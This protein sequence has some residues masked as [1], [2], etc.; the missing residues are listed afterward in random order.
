MFKTYTIKN[1]KNIGPLDSR[2]FVVLFFIIYYLIIFV[3][4]GL[5]VVDMIAARTPF[6]TI[7]GRSL[8]LFAYSVFCMQVILGSRIKVLDR[9][10]GLDR[11]LRFHRR[12]AIIGLFA[13]AV[14]PLALVF[15][16][17]VHEIF[18]SIDNI[19]IICGK[20]AFLILIIGVAFALFRA[21]IKLDYN[22]WH[23]FHK[24]M[25]IIILLGF[26]HSMNLGSSL[27]TGAM[28]NY[29]WVLTAIPIAVFIFKNSIG[30]IQRN[31]FQVVEVKKENHNVW[32]L[33]MTPVNS[34]I[35]KYRPGQFMFLTLKR[36][37]YR[38]EEHPFTIS[39]AP[40]ENEYIS[41]TIKKSGDYT[42]TIGKTKPGDIARISG[43]Y[44]RFSYVYNEPSSFV[45][46]AGGVGITPLMS[47]MRFIRNT[48]DGRPVIL[49][50]ANKAE[51]DIIFLD[52]FVEFPQNFEV[53]HIL[54]Q[55]SKDWLGEVGHVEMGIIEKYCAKVLDSAHFYLCGPKPMMDSV[56]N[57]LTEIGIDHSR[58]HSE[59]FR[60]N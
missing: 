22:K 58:I 56:H 43:P 12:M 7:I 33:D 17:G 6:F 46:I 10:F 53:V 5:A 45:F 41:A 16:Y 29:W 55:S 14:H 8:A 60:L 2:L 57:I 11:I 42:S 20:L 27:E 15:E 24:L 19:Y 34:D 26:V 47:M 38:P 4:M 48:D 9:V 32:T 1:Y 50:Y 54:S 37:G 31:K 30:F 3:P 51:D 59:V 13:I 44:G 52:E 28:R 49:L 36:P 39:S 40:T 21:K 18:L 35:F 25:L 23:T